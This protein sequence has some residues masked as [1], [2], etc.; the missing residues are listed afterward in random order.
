MS[1][2]QKTH[3]TKHYES[4]LQKWLKIPAL[5]ASMAFHHFSLPKVEAISLLPESGLGHVTC[6]G[7]WDI[8]KCD[9]S[10]GLK[11]DCTLGSTLS[12][13]H[14]EPCDHCHVNKPKPPCD[15]RPVTKSSPLAPA[16]MG[17]LP[18]CEHGHPGRAAHLGCRPNPEF[19]QASLDTRNCLTD[20]QN[21][22]K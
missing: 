6:F 5:P 13:H 18:R 11:S 15:E 7:E 16:D 20:P 8:S 2:K 3:K 22:E 1:R 17:Q 21:H 9:A 19:S 14:W 10:R 12:W 4:R